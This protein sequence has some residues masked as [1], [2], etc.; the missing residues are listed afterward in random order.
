LC[1]NI[2]TAITPQKFSCKYNLL[3]RSRY[4]FTA[5]KR[6]GIEKRKEMQTVFIGEYIKQRRKA[7]N[8]TQE[9][10]CDGICDPA[11]ISRIETGYQAP[12]RSRLNALL[13]R[14][15]LPDDRYY[16]ISTKN[17]LEIEALKKE[18]VACS[19]TER[20]EE[21]I[22]K[23]AQLEKI[24][25]ESDTL[26]RQFILRSKIVLWRLTNHCSSEDQLELLVQAIRLTVPNF[27]V[28][29]IDGFLYTFDEIKL[30]NQIAGIYSDSG[31]SEKA[32]DIYRQLL[33]YIRR[34]YQEELIGNGSLSMV[35]HNYARELGLAKRYEE[36]I[37]AAEEGRKLC[38]QYGH[39]QFL[40][41]F[42]AIMGECYHFIGQN[43]KSAESYLQA[44]YLYKALD[45]FS[46]LETVRREAKEYLNLEF[47]Y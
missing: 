6:T 44:Y 13:Q 1:Y 14:L 16:A 17:E 47:T 5:L 2:G 11:T 37:R 30:V 34:H 20:A 35:V 21:G 42:L 28:E 4:F 45:K 22:A 38:I 23:I 15:G 18:I 3:L 29:H 43:D 12:S 9:Q 33:F 10:L 36:S 7:L 39:Y 40:P 46:A 41:G 24:V 27:D 31:Q 19:V 26:T 8:L 32:L 25:E